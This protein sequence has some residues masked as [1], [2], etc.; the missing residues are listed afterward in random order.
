M[1]R[2]G[3]RGLSQSLP[4]TIVPSSS[5]PSA[6]AAAAAATPH[7]SQQQQQH[8]QLSVDIPVSTAQQAAAGGRA[9]PSA[10]MA[11]GSPGR[12]ASSSVSR[13]TSPTWRHS[14]SHLESLPGPRTGCVDHPSA[15]G[16]DAG[17][18]AGSSDSRAD[19]GQVQLEEAYEPQTLPAAVAAAGEGSVQGPAPV[20]AARR[21]GAPAVAGSAG[22]GSGPSAA[23]AAVARHPGD[24]A[25]FEVE[26]QRYLESAAAAVAAGSGSGG[27]AAGG[28]GTRPAWDSTQVRTGWG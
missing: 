12:D 1:S 24:A 22:A 10:P 25:G 21:P 15:P 3:S 7:P 4:P 14:A 27:A 6:A 17:S 20:P 9:S 5:R 23:A 16:D 28:V 11:A 18:N 2:L 19:P 13:P 26:V 8:Q